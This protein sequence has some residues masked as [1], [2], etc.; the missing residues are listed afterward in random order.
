MSA[1]I[2]DSRLPIAAG[3]SIMDFAFSGMSD[4][5]PLALM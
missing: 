1:A 5:I 4:D 2:A 3:R